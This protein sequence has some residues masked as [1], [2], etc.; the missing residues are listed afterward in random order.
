M[1]DLSQ[2]N[3]PAKQ[4]KII[5]TALNLFQQFGIKRIPI[6]E[7]CKTSSVS[8]MTFYKYFKNKN[9][10][11]RFMWKKGFEQGLEKFDEIRAMEIPFEKK[12]QKIL[13]MKDESTAK[14]SH[15]FALDYFYS[16]S[17][18]KEF[19]DTLARESV[20]HFLSFIKDAQKRGEVRAEMKPEFLLAVINYIK[21]MIKE[22]DLI[23]SY[24]NYHDFVMEVNNFLFYGILPRP[25]RE[26][27]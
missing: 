19:F 12:L 22:N 2:L 16:S 10:L 7:I 20:L 11:V 13:E 9:E 3:L 23:N 27:S 4:L 21:L 1:L 24:P 25:N 6:E 5:D 18:L 17:E 14:I 8:K 15:E 26:G